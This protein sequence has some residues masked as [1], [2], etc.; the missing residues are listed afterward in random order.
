M[1]LINLGSNIKRLMTNLR[2]NNR[3]FLSHQIT[4]DFKINSMCN[5]LLSILL[6]NNPTSS[7]L[8]MTLINLIMCNHQFKCNSSLKSKL[9]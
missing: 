1:I 2:F 6:I 4:K 3:H 9:M 8:I 5:L 7:S